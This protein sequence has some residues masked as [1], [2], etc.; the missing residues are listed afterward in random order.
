MGKKKRKAK[1]TKGKRKPKKRNKVSKAKQYEIK[2]SEIERKTL[3]C[4]KC[5]EGVF[6]AKHKDRNSCGKCS[7]TQWNTEKK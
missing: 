7:F 3:F 1:E 4:P 2:G 6:M 5:G